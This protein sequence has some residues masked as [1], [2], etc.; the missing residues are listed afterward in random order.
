MCLA[1]SC[2][3]S[4][5][6]PLPASCI[7]YRGSTWNSQFSC[8]FVTQMLP[9]I[10]LL[11]RWMG[12]ALVMLLLPPRILLRNW[13][14][15]VLWL[16][17]QGFRFVTPCEKVDWLADI[18]LMVTPTTS[19]LLLLDRWQII[20]TTLMLFINVHHIVAKWIKHSFNW[21]QLKLFIQIVLSW[22]HV[23]SPGYLG[24]L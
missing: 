24:D 22:L 6:P 11:T 3:V 23:L 12:R 15:V 13:R 18:M 8:W 7:L 17:N 2:T 14:F 1:W 9:A 19:A 21:Y 4:L 16:H 10:P 5:E 20:W